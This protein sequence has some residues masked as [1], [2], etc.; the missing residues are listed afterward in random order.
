MLEE[1]RSSLVWVV[2]L[3][4]PGRGVTPGLAHKGSSG[5]NMV[6]GDDT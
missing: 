1:T 4:T 3:D 2:G 6:L 5:D